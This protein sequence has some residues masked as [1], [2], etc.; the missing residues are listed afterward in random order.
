MIFLKQKNSP[1]ITKKIR[2]AASLHHLHNLPNGN[3]A[4]LVAQHEAA[5]LWELL[6]QVHA[7]LLIRFQP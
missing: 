3:C 5:H 4:A 7:E 6:E 2:T 1:K